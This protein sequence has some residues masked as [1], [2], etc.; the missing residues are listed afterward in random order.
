[1]DM[2]LLGRTG[3]SISPVVFGGNVFGWTADEKTSFE[4]LDAFFEAGF[5]TIDTADVYSAWAP[6]HQ[7][8]ESETVIGNWLKR[9]TVAR[10][11]AVIVTK[12]GYPTM[13]DDKK[14]KAKWVVEAVE[15]SLQRLQ[16][17]YIDLYL[18]HFPDDDTPHEETLGA[19]AKLKDAGKV[20]SIGCSNFSAEQLQASL[21]AADRNGLPRYDVLQPEY[22]LYTRN[23]F[24]G[25]LADLCIAEDIGVIS[26]YA[27]AAGFL[28]GKYRKPEDAEGKTRGNRMPDYINDRG[29]KILAAL[30]QVAAETGESLAAI[31]IAWV[32]A[33][34]GITA[35]IASATS[36]KQLEAI[37]TAGKLN[38]T[39]AQMALLNEAGA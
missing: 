23:K 32:A 22:N 25:P 4:M 21:D 15:K 16:T 38:L 31:S 5:N 3:L 39:D 13:G 36:L 37:I 27:L 18:S 1:M 19:L 34:P 12:F 11:K 9:G 24:E 10:D 17:D 8:G 28:T 6:G 7:G 14:L 2:R 33:R 30:D 26:Y 35:P 20:R 29:L